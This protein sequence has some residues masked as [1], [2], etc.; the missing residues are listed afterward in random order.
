MYITWLKIDLQCETFVARAHG[1]VWACPYLPGFRCPYLPGSNFKQFD[2]IFEI[3]I[4]NSNK[5][6]P[7]MDRPIVMLS[8]A[9]APLI[10]KQESCP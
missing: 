6:T 5:I 3:Y 9:E 10:R 4:S 1:E 2:A 8:D 7:L